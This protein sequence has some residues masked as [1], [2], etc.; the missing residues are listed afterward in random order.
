MEPRYLGCYE[1]LLKNVE[2]HTL[3]RGHRAGGC[4]RLRA[5]KRFNF[6]AWLNGRYPWAIALGLLWAAAYPKIGLAGAAWLAPGLLLW[7]GIGQG[8]RTVFRVGYVAGLAFNGAAIYWLWC[9]PVT[10]YPIL[11]WVALVAYLALY[12]ALWAWLCWRLAPGKSVDGNVGI[13]ALAETTMG[14]RLIWAFSCAILWVAG[15]MIVARVLSGF[16]WLFLGTSQYRMTPLIQMSSFT[17]VYGVSFLMVWMSVALACAAVVLMRNPTRRLAWAGDV[18]VPA[19]C[20]ACAVLYGFKETMTRSETDRTLKLA[21]I[22]PSVPQT[23]K[24]DRE[25]SRKE[26]VRV[27]E[28]SRAALVLRPDVLIWPEAATPGLIRYEPEIANLVTNVVQK[29][30]IWLILGADDAELPLGMDATQSEEDALYFNSAFLLNPNGEISAKYDKAKLVAFGEYVPLIKWLPFIKWLTP[31]TG[32]FTS[33]EK[34]VPFVIPGVARI[35]PLICFEDVFPHGVRLYVDEETDFVL[36]LTNNGWFGESAAQWQHAACSVMR[37]VENRVTIVRCTNNGLTC[38]VDANGRMREYFGED[39]NIYGA[40]FKVV[41]VPLLKSGVK[42]ELTFYT[43]YGDV[44]GWGCVIAAVAIC[45]NG[46]GRKRG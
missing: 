13:D 1:L 40:G 2:L 7:L 35:F 45:G 8:G 14:Q 39:G 5:L 6:K 42:R 27:I 44:F 4:A 18:I 16:P 33:G 11:G 25:A 10:F 32:G 31:I 28:L 17:G 9:I 29:N 12:P 38:W 21:L 26:F 30:R 24:W 37:A 41:E 22:Q 46:L 23:M 19:V 43:R 20:V 15:E 34:V 36:N 3:K